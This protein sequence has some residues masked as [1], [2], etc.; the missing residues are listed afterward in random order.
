MKIT[1]SL[2]GLRS[3]YSPLI[4]LSIVLSACLLLCCATFLLIGLIGSFI[5][6]SFSIVEPT[7]TEISTSNDSQRLRFECIG[8]DSIKVNDQALSASQHGEACGNTGYV[9]KLIEGENTIT[10]SA[11]DSDGKDYS[12]QISITFTKSIEEPIK[13]PVIEQPEVKKEEPITPYIDAN[14][15]KNTTYEKV[16]QKYGKPDTLYENEPPVVNLFNYDKENYILE[17]NYLKNNTSVNGSQLFLKKKCSI[18][19]FSFE[20][21]KEILPLVNLN[22]YESNQWKETNSYF[23]QYRLE[24]VDGWKSLAITC[25]DEGVFKIAFYSK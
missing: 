19:N 2:K 22:K 6:P 15:F 11:T 17:G 14:D 20:Q 3:R 8:I 5:P 25:T 24:N 21:A 12:H 16:V 7:H 9:V 13:E 23:K 1:N 4:L 18:N 10:V